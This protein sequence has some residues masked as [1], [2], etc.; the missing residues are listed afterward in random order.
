MAKKTDV[1]YELVEKACVQLF[2]AGE[3][4]SF[5]KVYQ[6]IGSKGGQQVVSDMIRRW[7]QETAAVITAKRE[8]PALPSELVT[9]SDDLVGSIWK[10]ALARAEEA[11]QQKAGELAMK[12]SEWKVKLD[13]ADEQVQAVERANLAI[14]AE[15]SGARATLSAR[16]EAIVELEA[17]VRE[18]QAALLARDEQ[19]SALREDLARTMTTLEGER[20]RHD[21][22]IQGLHEQ[23]SKALL[24]KDE[25]HAAELAQ[26]HSQAES[27]R[28]H[29]LV[30]VDELRQAGK[31][32][33]DHLREQLAGEKVAAEGYRKQAYQA[34]DEASKWQGKFELLQSELTDARKI[35]AKVQKH[36]ERSAETAATRKENDGAV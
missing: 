19:V 28:R 31:V 7:K 15:L 24:A 25:Q 26:V 9:A 30:Q 34:R 4:V 1:Q 8:N 23:Q 16:E 22:A 12:E 20:A 14:Q 11:Y 27:D 29:F 6:L 32:Q 5:P 3:T 36:R 13:Q 10:L 18:Q 21:E 2:Q 35:I 17:R 33:S